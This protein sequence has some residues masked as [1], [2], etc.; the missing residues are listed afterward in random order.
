MSRKLR[1]VSKKQNGQTK[2]YLDNVERAKEHLCSNGCTPTFYYRNEP[3]SCAPL[4]NISKKEKKCFTDTPY[5]DFY[6]KIDWPT[7]YSIIQSKAI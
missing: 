6:N 1:S 7:L 3:R 5:E 2:P 4:Y